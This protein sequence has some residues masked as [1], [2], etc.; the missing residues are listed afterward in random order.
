LLGEPYSFQFES[1]GGTGFRSHT[2][3]DSFV[4]GD[5][6]LSLSVSGLLSGTPSDTGTVSFTLAVLDARGSVDLRAFDLVI[7]QPWM[8]GD[9][10]DDGNVTL[11]DISILID[12]LYISKSPLDIPEAGNV[13]G[14]IDGLITLGD[15]SRLIDHVY[16][17]K[18]PLD[19]L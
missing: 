3:W 11:S 18:E 16:I 13:N 14:S 12:H 10:N 8:C 4:L 17:S 19:C 5:I 9:L 15:I 1:E 6:G 2:E 7:R